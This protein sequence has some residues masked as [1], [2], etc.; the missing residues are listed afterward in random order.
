MSE[1]RWKLKEFDDEMLTWV[2]D[3][4]CSE[5]PAAAGIF[6]CDERLIELEGL[7]RRDR[8]RM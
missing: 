1:N 4:G 5:R 2:R 3:R 8:Q 6:A 7:M